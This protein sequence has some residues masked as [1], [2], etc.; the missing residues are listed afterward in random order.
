[1]RRDRQS[2]LRTARG[3]SLAHLLQP[4]VRQAVA[5]D[6]EGCSVNSYLPGN[7]LLNLTIPLCPLPPARK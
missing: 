3:E 4:S 6:D 1:M 5:L 2:K 7:R